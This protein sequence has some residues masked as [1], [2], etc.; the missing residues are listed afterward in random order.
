MAKEKVKGEVDND[1]SK[2]AVARKGTGVWIDPDDVEKAR[3]GEYDYS[4]PGT[5][6]ERFISF[7]IDITG[8]D[9]GLGYDTDS[10]GPTIYRENRKVA[11][12]DIHW[13]RSS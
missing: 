5:W 11:I 1:G 12:T 3:D 8:P 7:N 9:S 4:G 13:Q 10:P 2:R 6:D